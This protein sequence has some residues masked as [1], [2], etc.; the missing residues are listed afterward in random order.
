MMWRVLYTLE[1]IIEQA[2]IELGMSELAELYNLVSH[3]SHRYL[4]KHKP[5][6]AHPILKTTKND[7]NWKKRFFFIRRNS[8]PDG[9][10][11]PLKWTTH[12]RIEDPYRRIIG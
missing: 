6:D 5:G 8:I 10:D 7:T 9:K 4:F 3:G 12:G 1:S 2:Y 11:L